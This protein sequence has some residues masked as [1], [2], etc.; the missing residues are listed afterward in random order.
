L[1]TTDDADL[2]RP[3]S[4]LQMPNV[5]REHSRNPRLFQLSFWPGA[6]LWCAPRQW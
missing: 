6:I 2:E 1:K 3:I 4:S 5:V